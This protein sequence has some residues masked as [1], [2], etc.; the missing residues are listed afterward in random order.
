MWSLLARLPIFAL[1]RNARRP[2][3][4]PASMAFNVLYACN[5]R[6]ATCNVYER[7]VKPLE[8]EEF[9]RV[10][11]SIG[12]ALTWVTF[13][14]GEPFLRK[15]MPDIA[16]A[17]ARWCRPS[18]VTIA[19]NGSLTQRT[20]EAVD[21][22]ARGAPHT[23]WI[24]NLAMDDIGERHDA[25]RGHPGSYAAVTA[26]H[27]ALKEL[28]HPNLTVGIHT[29]ISRFNAERFPVI[30]QTLVA[31]QPD[32]YI[33]EMAEERGELLNSS[34]DFEPTPELYERASDAISHHMRSRRS[35]SNATRIVRALRLRYYAL[36][37][38]YLR[39]REQAV[40][41]T[42]GWMF[43]HVGADG[44]VWTCS[45]RAQPIGFLRES[46]LDFRRIWHSTEAQ[47]LRRSIR[48]G[49]CACPMVT[50]TYMSMLVDPRSALR[51][52]LSLIGLGGKLEGAKA[53]RE[54]PVKT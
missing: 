29:C 23:H 52:G 1:T 53:V 21:R 36:Q 40:P 43:A 4:L 35:G 3:L 11:A 37:S 7:K 9:E 10:F 41:C 45:T 42:A 17:L 48:A 20:V 22:I 28:G 32:S 47:E 50:A 51:I 46:G 8:L 5:S 15:D 27:A 26:T 13:T 2:P 31:L 49:E 24:V 54:K 18:Y 19:T 14:G 25:I 16:L 12:R 30:Q 33:A 34:L 38:E 39:R 6:C 44:E